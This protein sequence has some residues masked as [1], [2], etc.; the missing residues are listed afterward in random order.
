MPEAGVILKLAHRGQRSRRHGGSDRLR[1]E[2]REAPGPRLRCG[3]EPLRGR[4][5]LGARLPLPGPVSRLQI[6]FGAIRA[7]PCR[8]DANLVTIIRG[9]TGAV[10]ERAPANASGAKPAARTGAVRSPRRVWCSDSGAAQAARW[11]RRCSPPTCAAATM[12]PRSGGSTF[13]GPGLLLPSASCG[14][15]VLWYRW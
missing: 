1:R 2:P 4:W 5:L 10:D 12:G 13:R 9:R 14:R 3:W 15:A 8:S 6:R 11:S 7:I